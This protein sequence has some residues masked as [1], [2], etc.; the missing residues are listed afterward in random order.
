M[1]TTSLQPTQQDYQQLAACNSGFNL[2]QTQYDEKAAISRSLFTTWG[3][4][5]QSVFSY[6]HGPH[7]SL[8]SIV[9]HD[10]TSQ[11]ST[12]VIC[13][14]VLCCHN[15]RLNFSPHETVTANLFFCINL[16]LTTSQ[17][18]LS[19]MLVQAK[20]HDI[21]VQRFYALMNFHLFFP[22]KEERCRT[23]GFC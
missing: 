15:F 14:E 9:P 2:L 21:F 13:P 17:C 8:I 5:S 23:A 7:Y 12:A 19:H 11:C 10:C 1:K 16:A 20:Q 18:P 3:P 22:V 6:Q 4:C